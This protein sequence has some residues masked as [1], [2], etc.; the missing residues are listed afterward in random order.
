MAGVESRRPAR[1]IWR[2]VRASPAAASTRG[3]PLPGEQA[4]A[5]THNVSRITVRRALAE[6]EREGLIDRRRGAGTFVNP[7]DVAKPVIA[8]L[9]DVLK[10]L[11][12]MGKST[13]VRLLAF[14]YLEPRGADRRGAALGARR[15][16]AALGARAH[17]RGQAVFLS[18]DACAR[19][20]RRHLFRAGTRLAA[21]ADAAG[22][23]GRFGRSRDAG[24]QR[25]ARFARS[26]RGARRRHRLGADRAHPRRLRRPR[27]RRRASARAL[28]PRSLC[29]PHGSGAHRRR[30]RPAL[31]A[32]R[33]FERRPTFTPAGS[34]RPQGTKETSHDETSIQVFPAERARLGRRRHRRP[35]RAR[36]SS[37]AS[38][39]P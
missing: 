26:R 27:S 14:G 34:R 19:A 25:G 35:R 18:D 31:V 8:D 5:A 32:G 15:A 1:S 37:R 33:Q 23:L 12:E 3:A 29:V 30:R 21:A 38:R 9:A 24:D 13:D 2:C 16:R 4:L 7:R 10:N 39:R 22:A 17:H 11:V 20:D 6:L 36:L 28:S